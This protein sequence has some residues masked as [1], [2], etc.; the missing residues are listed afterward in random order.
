MQTSKRPNE[1]SRSVEAHWEGW[2]FNRTI[3]PTH[4]KSCS[5]CRRTS[6][7]LFACVLIW[8]SLYAQT[9]AS[10]S[11]SMNAAQGDFSGLVEI[12][13]G[14]RLYLECH[15]TGSPT[16]ILESG[17]RNTAA[18]WTIS[19]HPGQKPVLPE[20]AEFTHVCAYD[21]PGTTL[22]DNQ[23]SRSDPVPMPRTI[24]E[25]V[26]DLHALLT[27][28]QI[29][30]PY[31][32]TAHSLGGIMARM[33]TATYPYSIVGLVL[34]DAYPENLAELLGPT[35]G[36][37]FEQLAM[38]VPPVFKNYPDLEN[39][40]FAAAADLMS[41]TAKSSRCGPCP[42]MSSHGACPLLYLRAACPPVFHWTWRTPG[43]P[44]KINWRLCCLT[45]SIG[46]HARAST[47]S[48][49]SS[50]FLLSMLYGK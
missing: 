50:H 42:Y 37:L 44:G 25:I 34:V 13:N 22:S 29:S 10:Q 24:P 16:V 45:H 31:V 18:I 32:L 15:G 46:L 9:G 17:F 12:G 2:G 48:K 14:R 39:I 23:F 43:V 1:R 47:T 7:L 8:P 49:W 21:R 4:L 20:V 40:D 5:Y 19:D 33:Y 3:C 6:R 41:K 30:G 26:S 28:A 27:A 11:A 35:N 36:L 38:S